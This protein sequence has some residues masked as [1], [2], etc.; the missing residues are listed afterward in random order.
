MKVITEKR[1]AE[2]FFSMQRHFENNNY[3]IVDY[4]WYPIRIPL[5]RFVKKFPVRYCQILGEAAV[6]ETKL[7]DLLIPSFVEKDWYIVQFVEDLEER[8]QHSIR[9]KDR[10]HG[11]S[12][13]FSQSCYMIQN[14]EQEL[15]NSFSEYI[16]NCYTNNLIVLEVLCIYIKMF[17]LKFKDNFLW[18]KTSLGDKIQAYMKLVDID[19]TKYKSSFI[20][21]FKQNS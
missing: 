11:I 17:K 14:D 18:E 4:Q 9:W 5:E 19:I 1:V 16:L 10:L 6:T 20:D 21:I 8:I 15:D 12:Y 2:V 7:F 3:S 13:H